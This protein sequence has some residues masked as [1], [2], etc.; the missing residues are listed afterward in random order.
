MRTQEA[1][2]SDSDMINLSNPTPADI[3]DLLAISFEVTDDYI[4]RRLAALDEADADSATAEVLEPGDTVRYIGKRAHW[5][6]DHVR[7][8]G[9]V[10]LETMTGDARRGGAT[11]RTRVADRDRIELVRKGN[12][13]DDFIK[14]MDANGGRVDASLPYDHRSGRFTG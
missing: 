11:Y 7:E 6:A 4:A 10:E 14:A 2:V 1:T 9:R 13:T 3:E 5:T 8:D 12:R